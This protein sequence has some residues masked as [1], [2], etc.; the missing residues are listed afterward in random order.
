MPH[1]TPRM[2][3]PCAQPVPHAMIFPMPDTICLTPTPT[4]DMPPL[5]LL[6]RPE[7]DDS[8]RSTFRYGVKTP[9]MP[10]DSNSSYN[11]G[12]T[13][14]SRTGLISFRVICAI[15]LF[16][17]TIYALLAFG[18]NFEI[19]KLCFWQSPSQ[20]QTLKDPEKI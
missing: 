13:A 19:R 5:R 1:E 16:E 2:G 9:S 6:S 17:H 15:Y 10:T 7:V 20:L 8:Q 14:P 12:A 18:C 4:P 3:I 11:P